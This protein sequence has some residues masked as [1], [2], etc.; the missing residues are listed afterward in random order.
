MD[1]KK[2]KIS[3]PITNHLH[4]GHKLELTGTGGIREI[5]LVPMIQSAFPSSTPFARVPSILS[6][7]PHCSPRSWLSC[8]TAH[9]VFWPKRRISNST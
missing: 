7:P 1:A 3:P 4:T 8:A 5:G 9:A 6:M 2:R